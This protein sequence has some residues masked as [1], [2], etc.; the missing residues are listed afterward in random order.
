MID[1][2]NQ[3]E[4]KHVSSRATSSAFDIDVAYAASSPTLQ[5]VGGMQR[6]ASNM[7]QDTEPPSREFV[8]SVGLTTKK[9]LHTHEK[10]V[11]QAIAGCLKDHLRNLGTPASQIEYYRHLPESSAQVVLAEYQIRYTDPTGKMR[12]VTAAAGYDISSGRFIAPQTFRTADQQEHLLTKANLLNLQ[13]PTY[14]RLNPSPLQRS[15]T[16]QYRHPDPIRTWGTA[17]PSRAKMA[18]IMAKYFPQVFVQGLL[19][20]SVERSV[21]R[22]PRP[23]RAQMSQVI[24]KFHA[25]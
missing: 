9:A 17:R 6:V 14:Q 16:P 7:L 25:K 10:R 23:S 19:Q 15:Q 4:F 13:P 8:S 24:A 3:L 21:P 2:S 20:G 5:R 22:Y 12:A 11:L 1:F 18:T